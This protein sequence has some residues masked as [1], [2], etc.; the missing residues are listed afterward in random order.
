MKLFRSG[1]NLGLAI[2][3]ICLLLPGIAGADSNV[4]LG[5]AVTLNGTFFTGGWGGG[6]TVGKE[7]VVDGV[8]FPRATRWDQGAVWWDENYGKATI[9]IDLGG[10]YNINSLIVQADDNDTYRVS[11]WAFGSWQTAWD[12]PYAFDYG[13]QTRP[14][15]NDDTQKY[16]L[17]GVITTN[18]LQ[19]EATGGDV[20][21]SV[22]EIQAYG[23]AAPL[24]NTLLLLA[25][26]LVGLRAWRRKFL[27]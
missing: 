22:S 12:V 20:L 2:L 13:M 27:P 7:T 9:E 15:P 5:K 18:K 23:S 19:F 11:Y 6:L 17:P 26:G 3:T 8:F 4:A 16:L 1:M 24:P 21:Y 10:L 25:S 14:N